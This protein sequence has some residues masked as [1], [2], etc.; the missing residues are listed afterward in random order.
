M[1]GDLINDKAE[2]KEDHIKMEESMLIRSLEPSS[3][4]RLI[5][6]DNG[7]MILTKE[8]FGC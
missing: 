3:I 5:F 8:G 2:Q 1:R 7:V 6:A 4:V